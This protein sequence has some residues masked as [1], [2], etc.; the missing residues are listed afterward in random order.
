M[1]IN[2]DPVNG[3]GF[4]EVTNRAFYM[5]N[6]PV[7]GHHTEFGVDRFLLQETLCYLC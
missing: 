7:G 3:C 2:D 1:E 5:T 4:S 6:V